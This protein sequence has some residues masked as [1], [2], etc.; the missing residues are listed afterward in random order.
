[1]LTFS[2][3]NL[4]ARVNVEPLLVPLRDRPSYKTYNMRK[5]LVPKSCRD[6]VSH[7]WGI[8]TLDRLL[9]LINYYSYIFYL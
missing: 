1:M 3:V 4:I 9:S 7:P 5:Y 6:R 2:A 8:Y